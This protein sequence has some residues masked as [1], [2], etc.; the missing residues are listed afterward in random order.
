M[1][2]RR[3][4]ASSGGVGGGAALRQGLS[5]GEGAGSRLE[6][7]V[8]VDAGVDGVLAAKRVMVALVMPG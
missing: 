1:P 4:E 6:V 2:R 5:V 7:V 8:P 3:F